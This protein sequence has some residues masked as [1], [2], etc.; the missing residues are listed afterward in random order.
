[1]TPQEFYRSF[2]RNSLDGTQ[3]ALFRL[4][5]NLEEH[6]YVGFVLLSTEHYVERKHPLLPLLYLYTFL[7]RD[8]SRLY[9]F[10]SKSSHMLH[11]AESAQKALD[12]RLLPTACIHDGVCRLNGDPAN[13]LWVRS[14]W[15][16]PIGGLPD[17]LFTAIIGKIPLVLEEVVAFQKTNH[18]LR[19]R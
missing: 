8:P 11:I 15:H 7:I 3:G 16:L 9:P 1:M 10:G 4:A 14:E 5:M 13:N 19:R 18:H 17:N 12:L 2:Q 6:G